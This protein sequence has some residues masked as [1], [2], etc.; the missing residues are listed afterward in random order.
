MSRRQTL[1]GLAAGLA[2]SSASPET[3]ANGVEGGPVFSP[4]RPDADRYGAAEGFPVRRPTEEPEN[5]VGAFSHFDKLFPTRRIERAAM[6]WNFQRSEATIHYRYNGTRLSL[7]DYVA[8]NPVTGLLI[9]QGDDIL[10]ERY[11]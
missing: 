11:Q 1:A 6:P 8:R 3:R 9:A 10:F 2:C 5:C 7:A 4:Q